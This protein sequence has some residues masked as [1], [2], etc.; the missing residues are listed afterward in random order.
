MLVVDAQVHVWGANTAERPWAPGLKPHRPEPLEVPELLERMRAAGVDRAVLVPPRIEA[1]RNDLSTDAAKTCPDQFA[2][3]GRLDPRAP[4]AAPRLR[5]WRD[6]PGMLGLR[7]TLKK[8]LENLLTEG[9][10]DV[11]WPA[12][13][14][15]GLPLYVAVTQRNSALVA[16]IAA[17]HPQLRLVLDHLAIESDKLKDEAAFR[18]LDCVLALAKF[19]NV[20]VKATALPCYTVDSYPYRSLHT[21]LKRVIEAYG[22]QRV[23]W[24]SDL[25][26]LRGSYRE[27]VTMFTE[28]M[29]WL[30]K[31]DLEWIVGRGLCEWLGWRT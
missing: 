6:Q 26:R 24:G 20:A 17:R 12:A 14:E 21:N 4:D 2:V 1:G 16:N 31:S 27:C 13:E 9:H 18:D 30:S 15:A 25:S 11:I 28:E 5:N 29:P 19:A 8:S 22:P 7:F 3:M 10:M 23:F